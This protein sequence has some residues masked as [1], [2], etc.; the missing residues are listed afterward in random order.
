MELGSRGYTTSQSMREGRQVA[1][2]EPGSLLT[3][4][5]KT[6]IAV[7][8][9]AEYFSRFFPATQSSPELGLQPS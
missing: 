3:M 4:T 6:V 5:L 9:R 7:I 2:C 1:Q 8:G